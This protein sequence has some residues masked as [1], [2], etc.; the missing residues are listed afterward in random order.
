L[1]LLYESETYTIIGAAMAVHCELGSGF[2]ESVYQEALEYEF[3][4][5]NIPAHREVPLQILYKN[6]LLSKFYIADFVCYNKIIIELKSVT[7]LHNEHT[8]QVQNYLKATK[9]VTVK[10]TTS[11]TG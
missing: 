6:R 8:A 3:A 9:F 11:S 4:L 10:T 1:G 5:N 7:S 2:L